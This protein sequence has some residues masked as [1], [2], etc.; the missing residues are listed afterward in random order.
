MSKK[1]EG[2]KGEK[3]RFYGQIKLLS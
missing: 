1:K 3:P 2:K